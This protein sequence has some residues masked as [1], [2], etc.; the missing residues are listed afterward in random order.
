MVISNQARF[1]WRI[2]AAFACLIWVI[3][4][5]ANLIFDLF[6]FRSLIS[7]PIWNIFV[8]MTIIGAGFL[9]FFPLQF[10]IY[11]GFCCFWGLVNIASGGGLSGVLMY[12]LGLV[13]A[14][15][16]GFF[17]TL[18]AFKVVMAGVVLMVALLF[19]FRYG[20]NHVMGTLLECLELLT[21]AVLIAMLFHQEL[22]T[23]VKKKKAPLLRVF[24]VTDTELKLNRDRFTERDFLILWGIHTRTKYEAI[25]SEQQMGLSTLK[26]RLALLF[27]LLEVRDRAQFLEQYGKHTLVWNED[28]L[29]SAAEG[30]EQREAEILEFQPRS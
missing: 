11:A 17:K 4:L 15:R 30:A 25:A 14:L 20:I 23:L 28:Q 19:Q 24:S 29:D 27:G 6:S 3:V 22:A 2:I 5:L 1:Y 26:E 9:I 18:P 8:G 10:Y 13:F 7:L 21:T 16:M 12:A